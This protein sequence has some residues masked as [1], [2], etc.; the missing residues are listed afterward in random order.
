MLAYKMVN[1][2]DSM[3]GY[4]NERYLQ[5]GCAAAHI[6][7]MANYIPARLTA[8]LMVL[9]VGRPGLLRFVGKYGNRHASPNSGYPES[10]LAGILNCRFGGPHVYFGEIVYKPFIGDK[11]RFIHTQDMH[12]AVDINRR[13]EIL[14]VIVNIVCLYL[15]G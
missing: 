7:D 14:M 3:V 2:L 13:A 15:V 6:D 1:T 12:K 4:K 11:D 8:L 10:A 5:F 9:S